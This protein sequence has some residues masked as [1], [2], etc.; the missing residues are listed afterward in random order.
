VLLEVVGEELVFQQTPLAV[1]LAP[2][3][4]IVVA[5]LVAEQLVIE[6]TVFVVVI[7]G[8]EILIQFP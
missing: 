5:P 1:I 2:P 8:A 4:S 6:E 7:V 3:S